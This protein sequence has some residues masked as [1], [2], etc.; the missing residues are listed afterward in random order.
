[1]SE[2]AAETLP[3]WDDQR[4]A[5]LVRE[6]EHFEVCVVP[7]IYNDRLTVAPLGDWSGYSHGWCYDKGG[8]AFLAALA[9]DPETQDM[10]VGWKKQATPGTRTIP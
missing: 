8:T 1:V 6:T 5:W 10:P 4:R 7:M 9:W 3:R 2:T